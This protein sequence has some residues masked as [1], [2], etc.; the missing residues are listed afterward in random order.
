MSDLFFEN[1]I[2]DRLLICKVVSFGEIQEV[3]PSTLGK[4]SLT[5]KSR[6]SYRQ[7]ES[8]K[9]L[10]KDFKGVRWMPWLYWPMKDAVSCDKLRRGASNL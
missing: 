8:L 4:N 10:S 3:E 5:N 6:L 7:D 9:N 1:C 2:E